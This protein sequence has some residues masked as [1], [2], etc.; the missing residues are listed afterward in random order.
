[1]E[2]IVICPN[3]DE[4]VIVQELNCCIFRH[5]IKI[6]TGEQIDPHSSREICEEL[7]RNGTIFGCGKPFKITVLENGSWKVEKCEYI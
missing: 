2:R 1:M 3:C 6:A 4:L 5:A 7:L